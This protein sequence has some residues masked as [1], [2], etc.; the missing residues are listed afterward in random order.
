MKPIK[1]IVAVIVLLLFSFGNAQSVDTTQDSLSV[2]VQDSLTS[3]V[4]D[5]LPV[6]PTAIQYGEDLT[7]KIRYGFIKAGIAHMRIKGISERFD[8]PLLHIQTTAKNIPAFGW[9]YTVDDVVNAYVDPQTLVPWYYEKKLR[10][11]TYKAD[12][13]VHY[14]HKDSTARVEFVR[15]KKD[16]T[17]RKQKR[18]PI[19]IPANVF[20]VLSAFYYIRTQPLEVGKS[21]LLNSHSQKKVY[22]LE[23]KVH[24]REI[25]EVGAGTF[26]TVVVEP[27]LK[28]E[29]VFKQK[30]RLLIWLTDDEL[31]IP[32]QM[33]SAVAIGHITSE[34]IDISGVDC[35]IPAR[36]K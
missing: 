14:Q 4:Q 32:V 21:L 13:R 35:K 34:L 1:T 11:G 3:N 18:Y 27:L 23:V 24:R 10:E 29:G 26:R 2:A 12:L 30:G 7:F 33:T 36:I 20:D 16:M 25:L 15:Y 9:I 28:G 31:K 22:D 19:K 5:S 17:I 6:S 8:K